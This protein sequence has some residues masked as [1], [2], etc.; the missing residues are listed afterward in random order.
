MPSAPAIVPQFVGSTATRTVIPAAGGGRT[1]ATGIGLWLGAGVNVVHYPVRG[2]TEIAVVVIAAES[3][4]ETGWDLE[5][6]QSALAASLGRLHASLAGPLAAAAA[7]RKW[8]L[9]ELPALPR[10]SVGRT[11]LIGDAA[12]P[13]LPHLAQGGVLAL[14]DALVLADCVRTHGDDEAHAFHA[15]E[16]MRRARAARVQAASRRN[17]R[18]YHLAPSLAWARNAVLRLATGTRLMASYDWLYGWQLPDMER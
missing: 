3:W 7:W 4:R 2:G 9:H 6:D 14:E 13:M 10:W 16:T 8:A 12:H 15:F 18:V 1:R 17:G 11:T 5:A